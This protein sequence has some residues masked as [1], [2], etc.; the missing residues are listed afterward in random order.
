M[1]RSL[2]SPTTLTSI[3]DAAPLQVLEWHDLDTHLKTYCFDSPEEEDDDLTLPAVSIQEVPMKDAGVGH[4]MWTTGVGMALWSWGQRARA[5]QGG[6]SAAPGL[7]D[8]KQVLEIGAGLGLPGLSVAALQRPA[9]VCISDSRDTLVANLEAA[10]ARVR[11]AAAAVSGNDSKSACSEMAMEEFNWMHAYQSGTL[12]SREGAADVVMG[13]E[14]VSIVA[15][16][17]HIN[18][19]DIYIIIVFARHSTLEYPHSSL[20]LRFACVYI[21][22]D[23]C[24]T[25]PT[26]GRWRGPC[27][28]CC[29]RA[30]AGSCLG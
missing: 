10:A 6:S 12:G 29:A 25:A 14:I 26:C 11:S 16:Q 27:P 22:L 21:F 28:G 15:L 3:A 17:M 24:T 8:G 4:V 23:R 1:T 20:S 5:S 19:M 30:G 9:A 7:F 18:A 2:Q 13:S